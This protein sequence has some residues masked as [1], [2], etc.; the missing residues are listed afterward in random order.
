MTTTANLRG[1]KIVLAF[2]GGLDTS[3]CVA[4]L[5]QDQGAEVITVCVDTGGF[6]EAGLAAIEA[7]ALELGSLEHHTVDARAEVFDRFVS[8]VVKGGVL[9]GGVYPVSVAAER[10]AQTEAVVAVALSMGADAVA[11]GSTGAGN[12]QIRFDVAMATLAPGLSIVAPVRDLGWSRQQEA[13]WLAEHSVAQ[14]AAEVAYSRNAGLVGATIGGIETHDSWSMPPESV[15]ELTVDRDTE[16]EA[17]E[18]LLDF[19]EGLP[20]KLDGRVMAGHTMLAELNRRAGAHGFG[21]GVHVG[22]TILGVKGRIAFEAPGSLL[23]VKAHG[24]LAK[25][26][27]TRMQS[28]WNNQ[29]GDF[30][31]EQLHQGLFY[32]PAMRDAE[33]LLDS[34]STLVTGQVKLLLHRGHGDVVGVRSPHSLLGGQGAVYGEEMGTWTGAEAAGFARLHGLQC[35]LAASRDRAQAAAG[36]SVKQTVTATEQSATDTLSGEA[37]A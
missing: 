33:A 16:I 2:S 4:W 29:L 14:P 19:E 1:Q 26:V 24:E 28:H 23:L 11:H 20:T 37:G 34:S 30:W 36:E 6:D 15:Y 27:Q 13:A 3:F 17:E 8:Y 25:L 12:D 21:R 35:V 31:G 9:R 18:L 22:D 32:D 7:R 5:T 10:T